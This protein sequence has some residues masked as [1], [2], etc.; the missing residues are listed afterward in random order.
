MKIKL[1]EKYKLNEIYIGKKN[2]PV[3][4]II[5]SSYTCT[6][7]RI[8]HTKEFPKF[9]KLYVDTG[10]AR[11]IF[12]NYLDDQG[13]MES[14]QIVRCFCKDSARNY[15]E[16]SNKIYSEQ[17]NWLKS[18]DPEK[19][20]RNIFVG[21]KFSFRKKVITEKEI[22]NCLKKIDVSAGLMIEQKQAM[23]QLSVVSVPAFIVADK[24]RI[25][26]ISCEEL[27]EMCGL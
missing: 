7:C 25:G 20:L 1:P 8:F 10:K 9:K 21:K 26:K 4:L 19:F 5:Y 13:A 11:V 2:A 23:H 6:Q 18:T 24:I 17:V 27:A 22:S 14:A 12:R 16:L 3:E 15:F